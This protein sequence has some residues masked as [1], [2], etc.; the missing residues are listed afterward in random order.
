MSSFTLA[1]VTSLAFATY[2][3]SATAQSAVPAPPGY[4]AGNPPTRRF[5]LE[6]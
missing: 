3:E 5:E 1:V 4:E 2:A 6:P